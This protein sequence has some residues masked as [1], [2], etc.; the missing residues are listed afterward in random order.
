MKSR[1]TELEK[2]ISIIRSIQSYISL[3]TVQFSASNARNEFSRAYSMNT[4][5]RKMKWKYV[6]MKKQ[7]QK[8]S[9]GNSFYNA[10]I[11]LMFFFFWAYP[12]EM[13]KSDQIKKNRT[14]LSNVQNDY[15]HHITKQLQPNNIYYQNCRAHYTHVIYFYGWNRMRF[16][17]QLCASD[18]FMRILVSSTKIQN[19]YWSLLLTQKNKIASLWKRMTW[20][21]KEWKKISESEEKMELGMM[22]THFSMVL[23]P[24]R[25]EKCVHFRICQSPSKYHIIYTENIVAYYLVYFNRRHNFFLRLT[26]KCPL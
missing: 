22:G 20:R 1:F 16:R 5:Y 12:K 3:I 17:S 21:R 4:G 26:N 19:V 18:I 9:K 11:V 13:R 14:V 25:K 2:L 10:K 6:K 23:W 24:P 8:Y 15:G 7:T